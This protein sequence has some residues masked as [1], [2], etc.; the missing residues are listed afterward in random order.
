MNIW[1]T[2]IFLLDE[3]QQFAEEYTRVGFETP[4]ES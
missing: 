3:N 1:I 4:F 2:D